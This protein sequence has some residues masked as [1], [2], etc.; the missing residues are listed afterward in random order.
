[1]VKKI[2]EKT[3]LNKARKE[4]NLSLDKAKFIK[5]CLPTTQIHIKIHLVYS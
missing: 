4:S 3:Q 2:A 1:M 5:I